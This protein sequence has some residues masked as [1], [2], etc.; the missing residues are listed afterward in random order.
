MF[1]ELKKYVCD[2]VALDE[3]VSHI[4][5]LYIKFNTKREFSQYRRDKKA[6]GQY[7]EKHHILP[8]SLGG[9]DHIS[10]MVWLSAKDHYIAHFLLYKATRTREMCFALNNMSR[11]KRK[12]KDIALD[13]ISESLAYEQFRI[14]LSKHCSEL[15][16][17]RI[18]NQTPEERDRLSKLISENQ[19]GKLVVR[20]LA[21]GNV[22]KLA[23]TDFDPA[24]HE[25]EQVGRKH[26]KETKEA[27]SRA[28]TLAIRGRAYHRPDTREIVYIADDQVI[29]DGFILG[30]GIP[31]KHTKGTKFFHDPITGESKR[32][33]D[34]QEPE[35]WLP[36]RTKNGRNPFNKI[37][38]RC[39]V[40]NQIV[41][42]DS[43]NDVAFTVATKSTHIYTW[44]IDGKHFIT[45]TRIVVS[46]AIGAK[47]PAILHNCLIGN[48]KSV[49]YAEIIKKFS[50]KSTAI[51]D[52]TLDTIDSLKLT[53][54]WAS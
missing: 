25:S 18:A 54:I 33:I 24:L 35:G 45:S 42:V 6:N 30:S 17:I 26:T 14:D 1:D 50:V 32:F 27:I 43:M 4:T 38:R 48:T 28:N 52:L 29:P 47:D 53:H 23:K 15:A 22:F 7:V 31:N 5:T 39:L 46:S 40:T 11:L 2:D 10:N 51:I 41:F 9:T 16:A 36:K 8:R 19:K 44:I 12:I 3:Y 49:K 20:E 21:T 37:P 34:G 13:V